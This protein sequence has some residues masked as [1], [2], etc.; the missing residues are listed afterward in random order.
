LIAYK[1][2]EEA[3]KNCIRPREV[4]FF[5]I[6]I[7]TLLNHSNFSQAETGVTVPLGSKKKCLTKRPAKRIMIFQRDLCVFFV[8]K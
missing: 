7:Y 3:R 4:R 5:L 2:I 6:H 8:E 1:K